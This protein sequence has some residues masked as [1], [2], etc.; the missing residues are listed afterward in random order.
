MLAMQ[1]NGHC[2]QTADALPGL[3]GGTLRSLRSLC[4]ARHCATRRNCEGC[5]EFTVARNVAIPRGTAGS[6]A[7][8]ARGR[9]DANAA[10][11]ALP[12]CF[13]ERRGRESDGKAKGARTG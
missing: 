5:R 10:Q 4:R 7:G 11:Q 12:K 8:D 9:L 2:G 1:E 6:D 13:I 3:C